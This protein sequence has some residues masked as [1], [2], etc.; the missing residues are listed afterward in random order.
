MNNKCVYRHRRLDTNE[1]FYVGI[2]NDKRPYDFNKRS[3]WWKNIFNL[4]DINVE[5]LYDNLTWEDSCELEEFLISIY[6]RKDI[7]TGTL[8]NLTNGGDGTISYKH[9]E[10]HI[11]KITGE[12]NPFYNKSHSEETKSKIVEKK[13]FK[14]INIITCEKYN[15][16]KE[17]AFKNKID[18]SW[19]KKR[20]KEGIY[21]NLKYE[22]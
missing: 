1:I 19:L 13:G 2:G 7:S 9:T 3:I 4:T 14:V 10:A 5:V 12:G 6:G 17:A 22:T 20:L 21:K 11:K 8:V 15:S 18:Y 16:I